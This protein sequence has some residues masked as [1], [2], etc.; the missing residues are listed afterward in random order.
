MPF[1]TVDE[2]VQG[3]EW[4]HPTTGQRYV[5]GPNGVMQKISKTADC[6]T[7]EDFNEGQAAQDAVTNEGLQKQ[8]EIIEDVQTLENKVNS[9]EGNTLE[10]VWTFEEDDRA[11][12]TGE[13]ALREVGAVT[14][15]FANATY[16]IINGTD[17]EGNT[18]TFAKANVNDIIRIRGADESGAEYKITEIVGAGTFGIE[19]LRSTPEPA[20]EEPYTISFL[21]AFDPTGLATIDYVDAQDELKLSL[22]GGSGSDRPWQLVSAPLSIQVKRHFKHC[23]IVFG[24]NYHAICLR[25]TKNDSQGQEK[26]YQ[27]A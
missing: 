24:Q 2:L 6:V 15:I 1:P 21:S 4:V 14:S 10:G 16:I 11:P 25:N 18:Y 12:R 13:F 20:D 7:I 26:Q 3:D 9:L 19:H 8:R 23:G 27:F 5:L 17:A 22:T